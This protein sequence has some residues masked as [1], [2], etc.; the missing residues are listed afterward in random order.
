MGKEGLI[1]I[2]SWSSLNAVASRNTGDGSTP[3][4]W[5]RRRRCCMNWVSIG[6]PWGRAAT[7]SHDLE[8]VQAQALVGAIDNSGIA[9][10]VSHFFTY[11]PCGR[12][13]D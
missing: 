10:G 4:S 11:I 3:S 12:H 5:W 8:S 6:V 9:G 13:Y 1:Q 7:T 2:A